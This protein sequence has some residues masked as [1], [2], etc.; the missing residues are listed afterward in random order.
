[1]SEY[2]EGT[3]YKHQKNGQTVCLIPGR[4]KNA[5]F[6]QVI[7]NDNSYQYN[8]K[9][10]DVTGCYFGRN[11]IVVNLPSIKGS[12]SYSNITPL[13]YDIMGP[14][15][16]FPMECRHKIVSMH[17]KLNGSLIIHKK[18]LDFTGGTGYIEGDSGRS[19]PKKYIWLQC[20]DFS[21]KCS[22]M[23]S[24]AHIPFYITKFMGCIA[25]AYF[26]EKEYRFATYLGV[27]IV[28][29]TKNKLTLTQG[30]YTL[31]ADLTHDYS[32]PLASPKNGK[33]DRTI[34]ESNTSKSKIRLFENNKLLFEVS[35]NNTSFECEGIN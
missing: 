17:H 32:H 35:S 6:I 27:K 15:K 4:T 8:F 13:K 21:E 29:V 1:M 9:S 34:Y 12:I 22:I 24:I 2:F 30:K 14:F 16:L 18:Q 33:M 7:T 26:K 25:V 20:N 3:Y 19:F 28:T 10:M 23:I 31:E 5:A 11:G